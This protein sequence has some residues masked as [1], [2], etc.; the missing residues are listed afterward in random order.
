MIHPALT[1]AVRMFVVFPFFTTNAVDAAEL[2]V[3]S[4]A[5]HC[6]PESVVHPS[7]NQACHPLH[8]AV[9]ADDIVVVKLRLKEGADVNEVDLFGTPLHYAAAR[10]SADIA[11][12]LIDAGA[13][14]E[15]EATGTAQR[16]A[17][18]LHTA[19]LV[20][21]VK[22]AELLISRGAQV[23]ARDAAD[24]TP[25]S[26]AAANGQAEIS[27]V[28]LK[29]G[30]DPLAENRDHDTPI[31]LAAMSG[32]LNVVQVLVSHGVDI[33]IRH[34][35]HGYTALRTATECNRSEV[36]EFLLAHG[37]DPNIPDN[38]GKTP[39]QVA[40]HSTRDLLLKYG[41]KK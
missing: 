14:L 17:H 36:V 29:A 10:N 19:A 25:L 18:P 4:W 13:N 37:A 39:L 22:V 12:V 28:L 41:A 30:A 35:V 16:R 1:L 34:K 38:D 27:E 8:E 26:V 15:A 20:N 40:E 11:E 2:H 32:R 33:N 5:S 9:R 31:N 21:A 7:R 3:Q 24:S 6:L 23:D